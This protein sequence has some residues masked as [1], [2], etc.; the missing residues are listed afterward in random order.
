M[1]IDDLFDQA[2]PVGHALMR[3]FIVLSLLVASSLLGAVASAQATR[4]DPARRPP[5]ADTAGESSIYPVG[6]AVDVYRA[7]LDLLF[8]DGNE[9]PSVIV[10]HDTAEGHSNGPCPVACVQPWPHKS[11]IDTATILAFARGSP[12]RPRIVPFG[13]RI[14]LVLVSWAEN[15]RMYEEARA[16][17]IAT[18]REGYPEELEVA[19]AFARKYPGA[20]GRLLLTKVGFNR[21]HDEALVQASFRCGVM[22]SS[23]E[24]LFLRKIRGQW[25]VVERIPNTAEGML[26]T[27]GM[28]Y[29]G[30]AGSIPSESEVLAPSPGMP[31]EAAARAE[32]IDAAA[33]YRTVLDSLYSF[34]GDS[35]RRIV[36]TDWW[37]VQLYDL[38]PHKRPIQASTLERYRFLRE[39]RAPLYTKLELRAP[40]S[41]LSRDSIP[42][43]EHRGDPLSK[44][45]DNTREYSDASP[46]WLGFRQQYPGAWGTVGFTRAAFNDD[47]TQAL[48]LT[49]HACGETCFNVDTWLLERIGAKWEIAERIPREKDNHWALD[50]LRYLGDDADPR[51]YRPRRI[52]GRFIVAA[53]GKALPGLNVLAQPGGRSYSLVTDSLG[54]YSVENLPV[55][56]WTT[57]L[58]PCPGASTRQ[59]LMV[60]Q[61]QSRPG[62]DSTFDVG[63]DFRQCRRPK[64]AHALVSGAVSPE[65]SKS[66]YPSPEVAA[67]YRGVFDALYPRAGGFR[68]PILLQPRTFR[69]CDWCIDHEMPRLI[70]QGVIDSSM[71]KNFLKLPTDS[72]WFQPKFEYSRKVIILSLAEQKFLTDQAESVGG[73]DKKDASLVGLAKDAYPGADAIWSLSRVA[74]N[75]A[76]T[77]AL[78]Q[79][80]ASVQYWLEGETMLLRKFSD[81]WRV[82]KRHLERG[83]TAGERIGDRCE[84]ADAPS[85]V[86][87]VSEI[88]R[89]V[90]DGYIS[91]VGTSR[92]LRGNSGTMHLRFSPTDTL[93]RFYWLPV[94]PGDKRKPIRLKNRQ[95]VATV[96]IINDT[97]DKARPGIRGELAVSGDGA[98]ITFTEYKEGSITLDGWFKQYQIMKVNGREFVG[99]WYTQSGPTIPWRGYFCGKLR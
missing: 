65:A 44:L 94:F 58:V 83:E 15:S 98:T 17:L 74:F 67:V 34:S 40:V 89:F 2:L 25:G 22:C 14:P 4:P 5:W 85:G 54:G 50:S 60:A 78:V 90:G 26:P 37:P 69:A 27:N 68:G 19:S 72:A 97:T 18:H 16:R 31:S 7:V 24:T 86:P 12:K 56:G 63:V 1:T 77:Q 55:V 21:S 70:R 91:S 51:A 73:Y 42:A 28:R 76:H 96:Q 11:K 71:A 80:G 82:V 84:P 9:S 95:L 59:P 35:P 3:P 6:D 29:R 23:D 43:M 52:R 20:W 13:Y 45:V 61:I 53:T 64:R 36:L 33:V 93:H 87:S 41:I 75:D 39:V 92:E 38:P 79:A 46:Y 99:N 10:M 57:L 32:G 62:L 49:H 88:E 81:G 47:R 8:T 30:P 66:T 48:V